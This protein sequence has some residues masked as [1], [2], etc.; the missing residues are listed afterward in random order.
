[1]HLLLGADAVFMPVQAVGD[2]VA[3]L[4]CRLRK[5]GEGNKGCV[6]IGGSQVRTATRLAVK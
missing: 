2:E 6:S 3:S 5:V 4:G 1:M